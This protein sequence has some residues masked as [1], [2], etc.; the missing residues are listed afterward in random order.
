MSV[1]GHLCS[2]RQPA[3]AWVALSEAALSI[4]RQIRVMPAADAASQPPASIEEG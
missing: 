1:A 2:P 4:V 3:G